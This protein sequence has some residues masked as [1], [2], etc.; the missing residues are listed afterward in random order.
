MLMLTSIFFFLC[1]RFFV[2]LSL[3]NIF[4]VLP[5]LPEIEAVRLFFYLERKKETNKR[6]LSPV[7]YKQMVTYAKN[8]YLVLDRN[9]NKTANA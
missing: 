2:S 8:E 5:C 9:H 6:V 4:E 1:S 3:I 7:T